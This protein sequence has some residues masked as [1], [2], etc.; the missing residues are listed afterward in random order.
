[1]DVITPSTKLLSVSVHKLMDTACSRYYF[2]RWVRNLVPRSLNLNLWF[3]SVV[4][5]GVEKVGEGK[6]L[7]IVHRSML[8]ED[9][10]ILRDTPPKGS[11][12]AEVVA[13]RMLGKYI[14][15]VYHEIIADKLS[16]YTLGQA[17]D[18]IHIKLEQTP[19]LFSMGLD[20]WYT[21]GKELALFEAKT[22][23]KPRDLIDKLPF[24]KQIHGYAQGLKHLIGKYPKYCYYTIFRKPQIRQRQKESPSK[25]EERLYE[26]LQER[27]DWYFITHRHT[28]GLNAIEATMNDIEWMTFDLY[29]KYN[30][31]SKA[32]LLDPQNWPR[33]ESQCFR[34]G[35]CPYYILCKKVRSW[36][37]YLRWFKPRELRYDLEHEEL[38]TNKKR[39]LK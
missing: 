38:I 29:S 14:I 9:K 27:K 34:Y 13:Q 25:F 17:E 31:L 19:V 24:D 1:M 18:R 37:R 26:D 2:W 4:H 6:K 39:R 16:S 7:S 8:K 10:K 15:T 36:E 12:T 22:S 30:Y 32:S 35:V 28:F 20:A 3:G 33:N 5:K 11:D 23:S 21:K